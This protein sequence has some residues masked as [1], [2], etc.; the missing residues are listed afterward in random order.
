MTKRRPLALGAAATIGFGSLFFAT[1]A[2][3]E[4]STDIPKNT[5]TSEVQEAPEQTEQAQPVEAPAPVEA[6]EDAAPTEFQII[7][8]AE[9]FLAATGELP[10]AAGANSANELVILADKDA[11]T[12]EVLE[13]AEAVENG[14]VSGV[15]QILFGAKAI[16]YAETDVVGGAG[17]LMSAGE[18]AFACSVGFSAWGPERVPAVLSAG[19][20]TSDGTFSATILSKP[21]V[22]PAVGGEGFEPGNAGSLGNF[23]FY[24]FGGP[25]NTNGAENDPTSTDISV[26]NVTNDALTTLPEV[27]DWSTAD[28]DDLSE[29]TI[30]VYG[31]ADP[32]SGDV[33]K[34][35]RTT[36]FTSGDTTVMLEDGDGNPVEGEILDGYVQIDG[37]WVHGFVSDAG[38]APGDS[39]GAV[40]QG[41][42]AVGLVSGGPEDGSWL[43]ATRLQDALEYT[44]GY[45]IALDIDA[46]VVTSHDSGDNVQPET[47]ITGTVPANATELNV[48]TGPSSGSTVPVSGGTFSLTAPSEP[49]TYTYS[50]TA[51]NG[52]SR[53][54]TVEHVVTVDELALDAPIVND[55]VADGADVT[56]SGMGTPGAEI[57]GS[58][59]PA[60]GETARAAG[61]AFSATVGTDGV[62]STEVNDLEIG[63]YTV[64]ASQSLGD[65]TSASASAKLTVRPVAPAFTSIAEGS[66]FAADRAPSAVSGTGLEGATI[67]LGTGQSSVEATAVDG[68]WTVDF[69]EPLAAGDYTFGATQ[70]VNG[71]ESAATTLNFSVLATP[72]AP[73]QPGNNGDLANTGGAP[74]MPLGIAAFAMLLVGGGVTLAMARRKKA[75]EI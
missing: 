61:V 56:L 55:V 25:G 63:H 9:A 66:A 8:S 29:S 10:V 68:E 11:K 1:P 27:T 54:E 60:S 22:E 69:G 74:L 67:L 12:P 59:A 15:A 47:E 36:G 17:Y 2:L 14:E 20:C 18:E 3:A 7:D 5:E 34:S 57:N 44:N 6:T 48:G 35:G 4:E 33:S 42:N 32:V 64:S 62:W 45:E 19:H 50:L 43:W 37:R 24:R 71:V 72:A 31:V 46:P 75:T 16:A 73:T 23:G 38:G 53:S 41:N 52:M 58:V 70:T 65:Q 30:P 49:G 51:T 28:S 40:I 39:G 21:S 13:Y 26:V